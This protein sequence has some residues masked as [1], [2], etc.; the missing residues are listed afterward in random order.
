M[1]AYYHT[2]AL[3]ELWAAAPDCVYAH[4]GLQ[5]ANET[6][7]KEPRPCLAWFSDY[8]P[9]LPMGVCSCVPV[10]LQSSVSGA[11]FRCSS[12]FWAR[13]SQ[14]TWSSLCLSHL[15]AF[16]GHWVPRIYLSLLPSE[17]LGLLY[18]PLLGFH[19]GPWSPNSGLRDST[20]S[21]LPT[22]PSPQ[23]GLNCLINLFTF[24]FTLM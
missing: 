15:V 21:M 12:F 1:K 5:G 7:R 9:T 4:V 24:F 13:V 14:W 19:V 8:F 6:W 20:G 11:F 2:L 23:P 16:A 17:C 18:R 10:C 3:W 22:D